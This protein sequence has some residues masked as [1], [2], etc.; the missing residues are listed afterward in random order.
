MFVQFWALSQIVRLLYSVLHTRIFLDQMF[1]VLVKLLYLVTNVILKLS[2]RCGRN[3]LQNIECAI[4]LQKHLALFALGREK[5]V[6][7]VRRKNEESALLE[8][9]P[10]QAAEFR[11]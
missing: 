6:L 1:A 9:S 11:S 5:N 2:E 3:K 4:F 7:V 8:D 10:A